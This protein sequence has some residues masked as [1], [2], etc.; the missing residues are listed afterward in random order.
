MS[1]NRL[2]INTEAVFKRLN[3]NKF[4]F[5]ELYRIYNMQIEVYM[6]EIEDSLAK[7]DFQKIAAHCH[8]L[9][10]CFKVV[11]AELCEDANIKLSQGL[12]TNKI[13]QLFGVLTRELNKYISKYNEIDAPLLQIIKSLN[14]N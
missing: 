3:G 13:N 6:Q 7:W 1:Q 8:S 11:G 5:K 2:I 4:L 9:E 14:S 10:S 12:K